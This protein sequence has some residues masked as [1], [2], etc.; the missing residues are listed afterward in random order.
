M[1]A[2]DEETPDIGH[3]HSALLAPPYVAA[4]V[5]TAAAAVI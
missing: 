4:A 5:P 2:E 1:F 3:S